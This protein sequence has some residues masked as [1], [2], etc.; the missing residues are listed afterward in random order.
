MRV[1]KAVEQRHSKAKK[2]KACN[3]VYFCMYVFIKCNLFISV[4]F[5]FTYD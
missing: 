3:A 2:M 4:M 5:L 1:E